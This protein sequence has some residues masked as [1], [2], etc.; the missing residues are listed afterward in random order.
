MTVRTVRQAAA[1]R[2]ALAAR[3]A[4]DDKIGF[5]PTM[6]ALHEGHL[7]L[8]RL[9]RSHCDHVVVSIFVNPLQFGPHED[10]DSYPRPEEKDAELTR[11]AGVD[12]LFLPSAED[13][14]PP[15]A[16][17]TVQVGP[18]GEVLEGAERPGHFAGV[19]TVVTK[20]FNLV[21]PDVAVFGQKDAQQAAVIKQVV[22]D[23]SFNVDIVVGD[24]VR[25]ADG[26][27][28][29][30]RN[31]YLDSSERRKAT[32]LHRALQ[33]G[34]SAF[35]SGAGNQG[36]ESRM[37]DVLS[38]EANVVPGYARVV[39]PVTFGDPSD[40]QALLVIAAKVGNTRLIDNLLVGR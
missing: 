32:V 38:A 15:G 29:S 31:V 20:L 3:R 5:V 6:G 37:M 18:I 8:V 40:E 30:S 10:L 39:D 36:T 17:S 27:A 26:L 12:L 4:A 21:Q 19:A 16:V 9:A 7:S 23:L 24:I 28:L 14:Y 25:E 13:M 22:R 1:L 11:S 35:E 34:R 33:E 2:E